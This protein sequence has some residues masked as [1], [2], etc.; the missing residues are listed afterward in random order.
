MPETLTPF[1]RKFLLDG[2]KNAYNIHYN[3]L[4]HLCEWKRLFLF[5]NNEKEA[6]NDESKK[7]R[8]D[9]TSHL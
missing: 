3:Q 2:V 5:L 6:T 8:K 4:C 7:G 9:D 1:D